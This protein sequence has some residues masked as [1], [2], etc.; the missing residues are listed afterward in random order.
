[1]GRNVLLLKG[2]VFTIPRES[3][4]ISGIKLSKNYFNDNTI[5]Y[6]IF[7]ESVSCHKICYRNRP[8]VSAEDSHIKARFLFPAAEPACL[9]YTFTP[10]YNIK[11]RPS[12]ITTLDNKNPPY[13]HNKKEGISCLLLEPH[14]SPSG[15]QQVSF[16]NP[17]S[18]SSYCVILFT[19]STNID[20]HTEL[21]ATLLNSLTPFTS[22]HTF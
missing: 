2:C 13:R 6:N 17:W 4:C 14:H 7:W 16:K 20:I 10:V 1:M 18:T 15:H 11:N 5:C 9:F 19:I 12:V 3:Y 22:Q 8:Y 21:V